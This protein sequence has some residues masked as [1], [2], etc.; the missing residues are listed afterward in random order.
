MDEPGAVDELGEY[1]AKAMRDPSFAAAYARA[2]LRAL[3]RRVRLRL[4]VTNVIDRVA[5]R[6]IDNG[7]ARAAGLLWR[8]SGLWDRPKEA[9]HG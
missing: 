6:L 3:P 8:A 2:S 5:V 7:H 9:G 4:A 1:L